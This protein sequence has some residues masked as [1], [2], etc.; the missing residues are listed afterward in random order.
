[1]KICRDALIE[2]VLGGALE[3]H[4]KLGPGLLETIYEQALAVELRRSDISFE[5]QVPVRVVY[6][7]EEL[8]IG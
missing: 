4:R 3:V 2:Q 6:Q 8:G 7:G 1:M 5:T